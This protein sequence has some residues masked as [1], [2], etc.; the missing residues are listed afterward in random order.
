MCG[1]E[2][3]YT[4]WPEHAGVA[5]LIVVNGYGMNLQ[6]NMEQRRCVSV[7]K[8]RLKK[9]GQRKSRLSLFLLAFLMTFVRLALVAQEGKWLW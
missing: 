6:S 7:S 9:L 4:D 8:Q 5:R 1:L 2:C 3:L